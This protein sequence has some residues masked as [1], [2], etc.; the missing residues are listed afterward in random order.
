MQ[1]SICR[2]GVL[3]LTIRSYDK[4]Y[5]SCV[6]PVFE[7]VMSELCFGS[8]LVKVK[9]RNTSYKSAFALF[10]TL[11]NKFSDHTPQ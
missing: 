5:L 10:N 4:L 1:N 9:V 11:F 8:H 7:C 6:S 3:K 2:G